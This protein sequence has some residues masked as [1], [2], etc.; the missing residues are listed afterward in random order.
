[1]IEIK[2]VPFLIQLASF[3][4]LSMALKRLLFDPFAQ[5]LD[6]REKRT[7]G[8]RADAE[9][10][11]ARAQQASADYDR[12]MQDVR[13]TITGEFEQGRTR[14]A[15]EEREIVGEAHAQAAELLAKERAALESQA[16]TARAALDGRAQELAALMVERVA[17]RKIA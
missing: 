10:L 4:L 1:M 16:G 5:V 13:R 15:G 6:D 8:V 2:L 12:R 17:G 9:S 7:V 3:F 14:T 11:R